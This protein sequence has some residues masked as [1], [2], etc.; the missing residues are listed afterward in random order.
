MKLKALTS[1]IVLVF[2]LS[3]AT[4]T[5]RAAD[6]Q[7]SRPVPVKTPPPVYPRDMRRDGISG[8]VAVKVVI[9]ESGNV[10]ECS[11]NKSTRAEFET[12]A[13]EAVKNW[14]FKPAVKGGSAVRVQVII[15]VSFTTEA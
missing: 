2:A 3:T 12:A 4:V 6:E 1:Y 9:D 10:A 13:L 8:M 5:L 14:K 7:E 15:P 11:V